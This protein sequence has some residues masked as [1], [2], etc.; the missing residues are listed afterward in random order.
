[1]SA[2]QSLFFKKCF[3]CKKQVFLYNLNEG[4]L[5]SYAVFLLNTIIG[6]AASY[7]VLV[8]ISKTERSCDLKYRKITQTKWNTQKK[9]KTCAQFIVELAMAVHQFLK[10][11]S[12]SIQE[13]SKTSL[14][15]LTVLAGVHLSRAHVS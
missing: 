8:T 10:K 15:S 11:E 12:G 6:N 4:M 5:F 7:F 13:K 14:V 1:M 2:I 9:S 3:K